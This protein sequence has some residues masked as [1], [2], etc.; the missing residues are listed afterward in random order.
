MAT[1][2]P[3]DE[4]S[5]VFARIRGLLLSEESVERAVELLARAAKES[6]P[7]SVG[8]G[9][10]LM[11]VQGRRT[12]TGATDAVVRQ[13]DALQYE[14]GEGPCLSAW[15][16]RRTIR[17]D[18][19]AAEQRWPRWIAAVAALPVRSTL[20]APLL[21]GDGALGALKVYSSVPSAFDEQAER[22]LGMLAVPAATLLANVQTAEAPRRLTDA[23]KEALGSRNSIGLA[24]G[25]LMERHSIDEEQAMSVLLRAARSR[26]LPL[27]RVAEQVV[28]T[29]E[30]LDC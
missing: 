28:R 10:S 14:L 11:D 27:A 9:V 18:D 1:E 25:M 13:A 12:S 29:G 16:G 7:G 21:H 19:T 30:P 3:L 6:V 23:L 22:L 17:V 24:K 26:R 2:L 4:L 5:G 15:A 20:S 8:A